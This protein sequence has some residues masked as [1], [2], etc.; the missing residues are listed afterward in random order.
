MT[1]TPNPALQRTTLGGGPWF[2]ISRLLPPRVVAELYTLAFRMDAILKAF[3]DE[4]EALPSPEEND[5]LESELYR[6]TEPVKAIPTIDDAVPHIFRFFE[7][8]PNADFG[9]PGPLVHL[10]EAHPGK[11]EWE[12]EQSIHRSPSPQPVWMVNRILNSDLPQQQREHWL[13]LLRSV[14]SHPKATE[15]ARDNAEMFLE[16]QND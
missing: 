9:T 14:L 6:I 5:Y 11:Y 12:L 7:S 8:H 15:S 2:A 4:L 13:S 1:L 10:L 16:D 3:I